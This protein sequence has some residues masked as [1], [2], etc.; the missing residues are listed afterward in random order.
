VDEKTFDEYP[1]AY[2][3][4]EAVISRQEGIVIDVLDIAKPIIN[5]KA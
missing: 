2:K 1:V 5:I 3:D 4:I